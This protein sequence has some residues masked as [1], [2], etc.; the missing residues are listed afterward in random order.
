MSLK[1]FKKFY[2][3][4]ESNYYRMLATSKEF[5]KLVKEGKADPEQVEQAH[6]IIANLETNYKR[7]SYVLYL[8]NL[9]NRK[10]KEIKYRIKNKKIEDALKGHTAEDIIREDEDALKEFKKHIEGIKNGK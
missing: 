8:L 10:E 9:P 4:Q 7:L 6:L 1:H 5:D 2:K 3:Q